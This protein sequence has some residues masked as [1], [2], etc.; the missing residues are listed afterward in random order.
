VTESGVHK[1]HQVRRLCS[2]SSWWP[3]SMPVAFP[4][5]SGPLSGSQ[6]CRAAVMAPWEN[7]ILWREWDPR[8]ARLACAST[9]H[10][11]KIDL[12]SPGGRIVYS[13]CSMNRWKMRSRRLYPPREPFLS[14][15]DCTSLL[16]ELK[17][18]PG[19]TSWKVAAPDASAF[20]SPADSLSSGD[21]SP[22]CSPA[23]LNKFTSSLAVAFTRICKTRG[24][25]CRRL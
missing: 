13:T 17:R 14:L 4:S 1:Y 22:Q 7:K 20:S 12:L 2:P 18:V 25:F 6:R 9:S 23:P 16:P 3:S 15:V 24:F 5:S 11:P 21:S 10:L 8:A 19:L